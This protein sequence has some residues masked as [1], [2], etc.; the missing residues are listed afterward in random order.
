VR[1]TT[2][3]YFVTGLLSWPALRFA[4]RLRPTGL[5]NLPAHRP[6]TGSA[7]IALAAGVP[8]VPAA[9]KGT[10]RLIRLP[11]LRVAYGRPVPLEDLEGMTPR[12]AAQAATDRLM[13]AIYELHATL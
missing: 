11:R 10:D 3:A 5:E 7:R 12:E 13:T 9:I 4:F 1:R 8:L 6:R 2:R